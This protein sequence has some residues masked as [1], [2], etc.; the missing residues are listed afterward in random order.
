MSAAVKIPTPLRKVTNGEANVTA[1]GANVRELIDDLERQFPGMR[2][3]LCD[4]D[5][6]LRR[7]VNVFVGDED[8][9]FMDGLDTALEDG[10]QVS[11]VPAVA[12]G[13]C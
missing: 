6:A 11:I 4:D 13:G 10:V 9:R 3:R 2:E 1:V 5:G 8:I 7:F 12:G